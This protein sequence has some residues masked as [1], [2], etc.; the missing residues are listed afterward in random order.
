MQLIALP[1]HQTKTK[2]F[3]AKFSAQ[4][5]ASEVTLLECMRPTIVVCYFHAGV[6]F[7]FWLFKKV[8]KPPAEEQLILW[9]LAVG[10]KSNHFEGRWFD[11]FF[12]QPKFKL[13]SSMEITYNC[14]RV[15]SG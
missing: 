12:E 6:E 7:E 3:I 4:P 2:Q 11:N 13:N 14:R 9:Y 5:I 8:V 15:G 10:K 1:V